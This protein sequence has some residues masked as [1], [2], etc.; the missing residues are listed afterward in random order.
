MAKAPKVCDLCG[1]TESDGR[2]MLSVGGANICFQ[3]IEGLTYHMFQSEMGDIAADRI[4]ALVRGTHPELLPQDKHDDSPVLEVETKQLDELP[5]P[6]QLHN[7]LDQYVIG[8]ELAKRTLCVAVYNH[9]L[10]L[11]QPKTDDGTEIEKSNILLAGST[12]SGKTLLAKT[13]ARIL[14][15]PFCIVD[16][17]T[18]TEAGYVGED[19]ENIILRLLQAADMNVAKAERGI[20]Y[21]DEIDKIGRKTQNVSI[22]RDVSGEGVQQALLKII[23]G[24]ECNIPPKGGRKHPNEQYIRVNTENILFICGG[25]FVGLEGIIRKRIGSSSM[26]FAS[27]VEEQDTKEYTEEEVLAKA[28]PEDF[29]QFGMIPELMGRL[30]I[31]A[32]LTTLSEDQLVELLT[33]PK[34][35]LVKQYGKLLGMSGVKLDVREG[36]LRA[37]AKQAIERG[38]GARALRGIFERL[39]LDVMYKVPSDKSIDVVTIT[40]EA[41]TGKGEPVITRKAALPETPAAP[42]AEADKK[43]KARRKA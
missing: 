20:I 9:Y 40:E 16:A 29:F 8:Q 10:R 3:C 1:N 21:V 37:M 25:A 41:V 23:E 14:D 6:E 26:G 35:A 30:P 13:L 34:N 22:T 32:P 4:L 36:A 38:T 19:V 31:F 15:V 11:R 42:A 33:Q 27:I 39:M 5:T 28:M 18:L 7:M 2:P 17:T 24:T 43:T 12:G